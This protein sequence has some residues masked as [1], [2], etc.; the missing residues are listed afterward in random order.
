MKI[1]AV[2]RITADIFYKFIT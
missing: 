2:L 1:L